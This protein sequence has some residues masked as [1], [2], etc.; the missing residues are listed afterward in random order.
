MTKAFLHGRTEAIRTVQLDSVAFTKVCT[1]LSFSSS[2]LVVWYVESLS[3]LF[4]WQVFFSEQSTPQQKISALR[5]ACEGHVK[6][7]KECSQGLGQDRHIYALYCLLQSEIKSPSPDA[8]PDGTTSPPPSPNSQNALPAIFTDPGWAL[9][10]TSIL[11][12]SNCGNPALRLFGF[13]PVA[14]DGFGIGYIIKN[15]GLSVCVQ[16]LCLSAYRSLRRQLAS[17]SSIRPLH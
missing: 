17:F 1:Q 9:L 7:T 4:V 6:L 2:L 12:T 15:E 14:A 8:S 5:R 11:C 3:S 13:G 10:N 16:P